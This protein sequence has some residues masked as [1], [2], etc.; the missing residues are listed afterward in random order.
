MSLMLHVTSVLECGLLPS[1]TY[2]KNISEIF[3][4]KSSKYYLRNEDFPDL[5]VLRETFYKVLWTIHNY[6]LD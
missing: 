3:S 2:S 5:T 1:N 4:V 6:G